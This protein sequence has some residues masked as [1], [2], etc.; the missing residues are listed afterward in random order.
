MAATAL[1]QENVIDISHRNVENMIPMRG[2]VLKK[3]VYFSDPVLARIFT[4]HYPYLNSRMYVI[5]VFGPNVVD[6]T[7]VAQCTEVVENLLTRDT[8][9]VLNLI[10]QI[11]V[12]IHNNMG[13]M[14]DPSNPSLIKFPVNAR[15]SNVLLKYFEH[16]D[17]YIGLVTAAWMEGLISDDD[18]TKALDKIRANVRSITATTNINCNRIFNLLREARE[19]QKAK[20]EKRA[21]K[22][23]NAEP[24][25]KSKVAEVVSAAKVTSASPEKNVLDDDGNFDSEDAISVDLHNDPAIALVNKE[26]AEAAK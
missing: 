24:T 12:L 3:E 7:A 5:Q 13:P 21:Q 10:E 14:G 22:N 8:K 9:K 1:A 16:C 2:T 19:A 15:L 26:F 11:K 6:L 4:R 25:V 17:R 18:K 23:S 20:A